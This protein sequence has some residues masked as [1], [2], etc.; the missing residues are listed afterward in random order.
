MKKALLWVLV[1]ALVVSLASVA[2]AAAGDPDAKEGVR[3][4]RTLDKVHLGTQAIRQEFVWDEA[5]GTF[6]TVNIYT[7]GEVDDYIADMETVLN[8]GAAGDGETIGDAADYTYWNGTAWVTL[9]DII[10]YDGSDERAEAVVTR[11]DNT[12]YT[13]STSYRYSVTG[14]QTLYATSYAYR[15]VRQDP[16]YYTYTSTYLIATGSV[17]QTGTF[18]DITN[19]PSAFDPVLEVD[20]AN[21]WT[22]TVNSH[23][24]VWGHEVQ[25]TAP[26]G[27]V[28]YVYGDPHLLQAG[29]SQQQELAAIGNYV[30]DLG[31]YTLD[32]SCLQSNAGFSLVTDMAITGPNDYSLTYGRNGEL[33]IDGGTP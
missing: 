7:V 12:F 16:Y 31:G 1:V 9:D 23:Y 2:Y 10:R 6:Q 30:F 22:V 11:Y 29:G 14:Y 13:Q 15:T 25:I 32:L 17:A 20:L 21:G 26:D 8:Q 3:P 28:S 19:V 4:T 5:S 18:A 24:D 27:T 33:K